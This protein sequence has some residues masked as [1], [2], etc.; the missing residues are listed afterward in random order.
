MCDLRNMIEE[1]MYN[2]I[3]KFRDGIFALRTRRFG[4]VAEI[5]IKKLYGYSFSMCKEY[6][7]KGDDVRV[8]VK[9][10]T[11]VEQNNKRITED[12]VIDQCSKANASARML[13]CSEQALS[14]FDCNIQQVKCDNFDILYY[15][16]FFADKIQIFKIASTDIKNDKDIKYS[17]KQHS[18]S[19]GEGQFH[20]NDST[21]AH[22][23]ECYFDKEIT[24]KDLYN[25]FDGKLLL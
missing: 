19:V 2:K 16:L 17:D 9:F 23:K 3:Q 14:R 15:G 24:Y 22:H 20:I 13:M 25:L 7:L 6:D 8:E 12:N 10:S 4:K 18:N 21:Y 11:V 5:M 1:I